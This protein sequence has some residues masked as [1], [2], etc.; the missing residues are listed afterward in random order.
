MSDVSYAELL[1]EN[2]RLGEALGEA[3]YDVVVV[4]NIV[5]FQLNEILECVLR[6]E[7]IPAY[8]RSG[9]Y[10]NIVQDSAGLDVADLVIVFWEAANYV[11]G[12]QHRILSMTPA[13]LDELARRFEADLDLALRHLAA[14][15]LVLVNRFTALPFN[16]HERAPNTL[17]RLCARLNRHLETHAAPNVQLV[18]LE[19]VLARVAVD[20]SVDWRAFY[21][22]KALY[23]VAFY[24][25]YA[26]S[27]RPVVCAATGRA[28]KVLLFDCDHTLW[29]GIL[30][31]DGFDGIEMSSRTKDGAVFAEVQA[32]ALELQRRGVL[33]GLCSKNNPEDVE[34]V[35][36]THPDL[37]IRDEQLA[38]KRVNWHD[39][40]TNLREI[41]AE[42]GLGLDSLVLVD[43]SDFEVQHVRRQLPDVRVLQVPERL[44]R[45]PALLRESAW[46]FERPAVTAEDARKT[47][48]YREQHV[49]ERRRD[50]FADLDDYLRS[51]ELCLTFHVDDSGQTARLAQLTQKTNQFNLTTRRYTDAQLA[52]FIESPEWRV[53]AFA[54]RD[55][56]GD[57]GL[58][59][60]ALVALNG[61]RG[62]GRIDTFLMSCRVIGRKIESAFLDRIV[63]ELRAAGLT[64]LDAEYVPTAKNAQ[65]SDFFERMG[66]VAAP[67]AA[68]GTAYTLALDDYREQAPPYIEVVNCVEGRARVG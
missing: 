15:P 1:A 27:I 52:C 33:L 55:R 56:F 12:L 25:A 22:S 34:Q 7:G 45:Y 49:R 23:S 42:L 32:L 50:D 21:A 3:R 18:D 54:L 17:D 67:R 63:A 46:L 36:H 61:A 57:Y 65:V 19:R 13:E 43:D 37:Q 2:R 29:R 64:R 4:S 44:Y 9:H 51:L 38:V 59:G 8:V 30:G 53:F 11:D 40:V 62:Q 28:R 14:R 20:K 48:M 31:E 58:T 41:A 26:E 10:D 60:L 68:G 39:K 16:L 66:F 24:K 5:T 47:Q 6:R 35:L